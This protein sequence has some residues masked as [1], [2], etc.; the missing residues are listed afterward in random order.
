MET[1]K[2]I[3]FKIHTEILGTIKSKM[4]TK[5]NYSDSD[6]RTA[7]NYSG[8]SYYNSPI[9]IEINGEKYILPFGT[10]DRLNE[11]QTD[12]NT[13]VIVGENT[14]L[15][16]ISMTEIRTDIQQVNSCFLES[17]DL[18]NEENLS[19]NLLDKPLNEQ[20]KILYEYIY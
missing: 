9:T 20:I 8:E 15:N 5:Y 12:K 14:G 17:S 6:Y 3:T 7:V 1:T 19:Y 11:K 10:S 18:D 16:Y 4:K 2:E 13:L